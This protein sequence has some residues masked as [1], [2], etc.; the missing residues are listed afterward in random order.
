MPWPTLPGH[1]VAMVF[2][3]SRCGGVKRAPL[4][5]SVGMSGGGNAGRLRWLRGRG[6]TRDAQKLARAAIG[7]PAR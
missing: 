2:G 1:A 6:T 5:R 3:L 4:L 7:K